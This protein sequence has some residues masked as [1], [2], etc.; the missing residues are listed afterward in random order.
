MAMKLFVVNLSF[1]TT[2]EDLKAAFANSGT[3]VAASVIKDR[4]TGKSRGFGFI[5]MSSDDEAK[6]AI[7]ELNGRDLKGRA[8][9]VNEARERSES[10]GPRLP[11][12]PRSFGDNA[13]PAG[14]RFRKDGGSRRGL[15]ARKRSL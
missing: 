12:G 9:S 2:D 11:G 5:E 7:A 8:I 14:P 3:C 13:P 15:R 4:L 10:R 1:E 6:R